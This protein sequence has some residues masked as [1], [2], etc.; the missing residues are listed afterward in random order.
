MCFFVILFEGK[1][2]LSGRCEGRKN[3]FILHD[4]ENV[5]KSQCDE[6]VSGIKRANIGGAKAQCKQQKKYI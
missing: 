6:R 2:K 3:K 4:C 1:S 5:R